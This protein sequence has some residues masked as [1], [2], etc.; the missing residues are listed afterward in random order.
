MMARL[1]S[2]QPVEL[3]MTLDDLAE[4]FDLSQFGASPTKFDAEDL[5]PLTRE[6][7]Q[8][9]P[10]DQV[11]DRIAARLGEATGGQGGR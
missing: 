11:A 5:W 2:S 7:N 10:F 4:G 9:L 6:R 3:R 1:G 8:A